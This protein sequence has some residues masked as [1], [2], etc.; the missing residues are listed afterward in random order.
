MAAVQTVPTLTRQYA[1]EQRRLSLRAQR[2]IAQL[3]YSVGPDFENGFLRVAPEILRIMNATQLQIAKNAQ[4]YMPEI[5]RFTGAGSLMGEYSF[6]PAAMVGTTGDGL[7]SPGLAYGSVTHTKDALGGGMS[8]AQARARGGAYL[9]T[10]A[11]TLFA[12]TGRTYEAMEGFSHKVT[13]YVRALTPPSCGRCAIIAGQPTRASEAFQRHPKCDCHN[14]PVGSGEGAEYLTDPH[15]YLAELDG[16][17]DEAALRK[18]LGSQSNVDAWRDYGADPY[19]L[20]NGYR[21][22]LAPAQVYGRNVKYTTEGM[23]RRGNAAWQMSRVREL[24]RAA[25]AREVGIGPLGRIPN[26]PR[27]MPESILGLG[28]SRE[29]TAEMLKAFGWLGPVG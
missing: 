12:D 10:A 17:G 28:L 7:T 3:W 21:G 1:L 9:S 6:D 20:V 27:L 2:K 22:G 18:A 26:V 13:T 24:S 4:E 11:E 8:L 14:V 19:A 15:E 29:K 5:T 25:G 16:R 23:S